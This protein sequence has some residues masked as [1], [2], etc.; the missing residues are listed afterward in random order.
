MKIIFGELLNI[1][2]HFFKKN[3]KNFKFVKIY[4]PINLP[5]FENLA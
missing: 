4:K 5:Q 2:K 1:K 3:D